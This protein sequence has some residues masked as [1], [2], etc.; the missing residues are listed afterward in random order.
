MLPHFIKRKFLN[1]RRNKRK[2]HA[3]VIKV[4]QILVERRQEILNALANEVAAD[5]EAFRLDFLLLSLGAEKVREI[6]MYTHIL[7][8]RRG[9]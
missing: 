9:C 2:A 1:K 4:F 6:K 7:H 3:E 8:C 5:E